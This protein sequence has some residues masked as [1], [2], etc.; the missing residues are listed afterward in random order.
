[1]NYLYCFDESELAPRSEESVA[2]G[3]ETTLR[4]GFT[5]TFLA[6]VSGESKSELA[7]GREVRQV[8]IFSNQ[9]FSC[10]CL[11]VRKR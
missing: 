3:I 10:W 11:P 7:A 6:G 4:Q 2:L 5:Q 8:S 1:M 9:L